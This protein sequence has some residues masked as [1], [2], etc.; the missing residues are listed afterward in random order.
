[1]PAIPWDAFTFVGTIVLVYFAAAERRERRAMSADAAN[2]P[3]R[4]WLSR[5]PDRRQLIAGGGATILFLITMFLMINRPTIQGPPGERGPAGEAVIDPRIPQMMQQLAEI[6]DQLK[7]AGPLGAGE[8]R[9]SP[10]EALML[11][12]AF[13]ELSDLLS[14]KAAPISQ[15][16]NI[17]SHEDLNAPMAGDPPIMMTVSQLITHITTLR[18]KFKNVRREQFS[19]I[20][21][22]PSYKA[23]I[24]KVAPK[25]GF[26]LD[27]ADY[28]QKYLNVL[29]AVEGNR[30][31]PM[32]LV[33]PY[34]ETLQNMN[35]KYSWWIDGTQKRITEAI[36]T[37]RKIH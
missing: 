37:L 20:I 24:Y 21:K 11:I 32:A 25:D 30:P 6:K 5:F 33:G 13:H 1:M 34:Q 12:T 7:R 22:Y 19:V 10:A 18:D 14:T 31:V 23:D 35:E 17:F 9:P 8:P 27:I 15:D 36:Q 28:L 29:T 2:A 16:M 26:D 3:K 4:D